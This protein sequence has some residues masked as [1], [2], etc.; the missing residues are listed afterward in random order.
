MESANSYQGTGSTFLKD[1]VYMSEGETESKALQALFSL[2]LFL[3][4][5][6]LSNLLLILLLCSF[7]V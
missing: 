5:A 3:K 1:N 6:F 4:Q 2:Y 7:F